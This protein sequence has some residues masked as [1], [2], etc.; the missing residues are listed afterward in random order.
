MF[1]GSST[2]IRARLARAG[3]DRGQ[4]V[5][6]I[7][8][9]VEAAEIPGRHHVLRKASDREVPD[10]PEGARVD[11]VDRVAPRIRDVNQRS[12]TACSAGQHVPAVEGIDVPG[13]A[14]QGL[15]CVEARRLSTPCH[16]CPDLREEDPIAEGDGGE[17]GA[18]SLQPSGNPDSPRAQVDRH[19]ARGWCGDGGTTSADDVRD[20]AE[21][22]G[23]GMRR[24]RRQ[25]ADP[26][27]R[28]APG[29]YSRTTSLAEPF[30]SEPPADDELPGGRGDGRI[31]ERE[32]QP[33]D[34]ARRDTGSP[35]DDRVQ[36]VRSCVAADHVRGAVDHRC[37]L[38]GARRRQARDDGSRTS[39][40]RDT[41]DLVALRARVVPPPNT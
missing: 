24:G 20:T 23:G 30:A 12:R 40:D 37:R 32:R 9:D 29:R 14:G 27:T 35:G 2:G 41:D 34:D 16:G 13:R 38:V 17:I 11:H 22:R 7:V 3:I 18:R 19:D 31:A 4:A 39:S 6:G 28:A 10:D 36:P 25:P 33:R 21:R 26:P 1:Y 15:T 8:R 5:A